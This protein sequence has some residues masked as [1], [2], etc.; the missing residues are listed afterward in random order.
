MTPEPEQNGKVISS[1]S[2]EKGEW[3]V[4]TENVSWVNGRTGIVCV[5]RRSVMGRL[6]KKTRNKGPFRLI[7][8]SYTRGGGELNSAGLWRGPPQSGSGQLF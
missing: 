2:E 1:P 6:P 3:E 7:W 8:L 4:G 5:T